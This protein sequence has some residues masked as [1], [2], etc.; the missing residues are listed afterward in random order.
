[1]NFKPTKSK[2]IGSIVVLIIVTVIMGFTNISCTQPIGTA[3]TCIP[4]YMLSFLIFGIP[5]LIIVYVVW[6]LVEKKK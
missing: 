2:T 4:N 3:E 6:S 1:M 5:A